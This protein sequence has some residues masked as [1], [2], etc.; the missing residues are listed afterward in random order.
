MKTLEF[1]MKIIEVDKKLEEEGLI[2][3][4]VKY[5]DKMF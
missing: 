1:L 4:W 2:N 3:N 5:E